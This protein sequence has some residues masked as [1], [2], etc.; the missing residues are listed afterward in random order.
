MWK[1]TSKS[2]QVFLWNDHIQLVFF[3]PHQT[4]EFKKNIRT[5]YP[6]SLML[7]NECD[8]NGQNRM[9]CA[10]KQFQEAFIVCPLQ[11]REIDL[12]SVR[13]S[14]R[15]AY[16]FQTMQRFDPQ[17]GA[18]NDNYWS[19]T[20]H[21]RLRERMRINKLD[22]P[23]DPNGSKYKMMKTIFQ[24]NHLI[25]EM[26]PWFNFSTDILRMWLRVRVKKRGGESET[27]HIEQIID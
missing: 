13:K 25:P 27:S 24:Q 17:F 1:W 9:E 12:Y 26:P 11:F 7:L 19:R 5:K 21:F 6:S 3:H 18:A 2:R 14:S 22:L 4:G 16:R 23:T 10:L 20:K 8:S 15:N